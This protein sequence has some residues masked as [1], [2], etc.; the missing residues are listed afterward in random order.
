MRDHRECS[1][2]YISRP[3]PLVHKKT[4]C[5]ASITHPHPLSSKEAKGAGATALINIEGQKNLFPD[6]KQ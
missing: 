3:R 1:S 6:S 2:K 4:D 5:S